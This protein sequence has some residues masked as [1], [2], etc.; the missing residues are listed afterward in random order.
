MK[1]EIMRE[2]KRSVKGVR[3]LFWVLGMIVS[4]FFDK[5]LIGERAFTFP[6]VV[7]IGFIIFALFIFGT[8]AIAIIL[9]GLDDGIQMALNALR[10]YKRAKYNQFYRKYEQ[11]NYSRAGRNFNQANYTYNRAGHNDKRVG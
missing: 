7:I 5:A 1:E 6:L 4:Y 9:Q 2:V 8:M 11:A 3:P 10:K